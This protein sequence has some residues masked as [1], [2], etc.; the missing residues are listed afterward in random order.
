MGVCLTVACASQDSA[1]LTSRD[2]VV[3]V[4]GTKGGSGVMYA[5]TT[6]ECNGKNYEVSTGTANGS[7]SV[8]I[9]NGKPYG[10]NC[11]DAD[12]SG[13]ANCMNGCGPSA[14]SGACTVNP[15]N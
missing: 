2:G 5:T 11:D 6:L 7:C 8:M 3:T 12:N 1:R 4:M 10:F 13:R 15:Q 9:V 14:G